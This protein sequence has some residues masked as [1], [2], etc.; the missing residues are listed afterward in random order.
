VLNAPTVGEGGNPV[1]SMG[2]DP[3]LKPEYDK[4]RVYTKAIL[5]LYQING[6]EIFRKTVSDKKRRDLSP[7]FYFLIK[8]LLLYRGCRINADLQSCTVFAFESDDAVNLCE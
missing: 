4:P 1:F 6:K 8:G 7:P 5:I 2:P 3:P